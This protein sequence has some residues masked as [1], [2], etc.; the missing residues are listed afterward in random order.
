MTIVVTSAMAVA[1]ASFDAAQGQPVP[2]PWAYTVNPPPAPGAK[3]SPPDPAP[4]QVPGSTVSLTMAQTRD[5]FNPPDWHPSGHPPMPE[6]VAQKL[7]DLCG[8]EYMEAYWRTETISQTHI[9]PP[10]KSRKQC[11]GIPTFDTESLVI[12]PDMKDEN[13]Y[14]FDAG[15]RSDQT[16]LFNYDLS[17]FYLNY[18]HLVSFLHY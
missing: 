1:R 9:N 7:F 14:S 10:H 13:G 5:A 11:L 16:T 6:A 12:D 3:P 2:P 8:I 4:K 15:I 17:V 18:K